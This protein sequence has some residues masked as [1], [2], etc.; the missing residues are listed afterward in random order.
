MKKILTILWVIF[1]IT[2]VIYAAP[3]IQQ[4]DEAT[5]TNHIT[6]I[7]K[8]IE[9]TITLPPIKLPSTTGKVTIETMFSAQYGSWPFESF[10]TNNLFRVIAT[11]QSSH[12]KMITIKGGTITLKQLNNAIKNQQIIRPFQDGYLLSYP[13]LIE[14]KAALLLENTTLYLNGLS[15]TAVIN[16]GI[17]SIQKSKVTSWFNNQPG[18]VINDTIFR[19]FIINWG[20]SCLQIIHSQ[21]VKLGY[22]AYL[23]QGITTAIN[24]NQPNKQPI[25]VQIEHSDFKA[26]STINLK[27]ALLSIDHS[28]IFSAQQYGIDLIDSQFHIS[29]NKIKHIK[30]NSGI[31]LQGNILGTIENNAI[32]TSNKAAIELQHTTGNLVIRQN[33]LAK[34]SRH[35]LLLSE[36]NTN[37]LIKNNLFTQLNGTAIESNQFTGAAYILNNSIQH[38]PEYAVSFRNLTPQKDTSL[39][40]YNNEITN[41][42]KSIIRTIGI[43]KLLLGHNKMLGSQLYQNLISGDLLTTQG[44]ILEATQKYNCI[45]SI[46][47][48]SSDENITHFQDC[49]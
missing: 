26:L 23:V 45:I 8:T 27:N 22:N 6:Q 38:I 37:I 20:G 15:G 7:Q 42:Q 1:Q 30:N 29:N 39:V 28:N 48:F 40:I 34:G 43:G 3:S 46:N 31:R 33:I 35:G 41:I 25:L 16:K 18:Y 13:I 19:P 2:S 47:A 11:Y 17:L 44:L 10:A 4:I 14:D 21:L 9:P 49:K 24:N 36:D 12:P 32:F 5:F